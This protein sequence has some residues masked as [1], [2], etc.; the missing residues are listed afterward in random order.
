[1][2]YTNGKGFKNYRGEKTRVNETTQQGNNKTYTPP[3]KD[4]VRMGAQFLI[5]DIVQ[6]KRGALAGRLAK[7]TRIHTATNGNKIYTVEITKGSGRERQQ[8]T[9][10][11]LTLISRNIQRQS[12][13]TNE[14]KRGTKHD[15]KSQRN[16]KSKSKRP[17]NR[18]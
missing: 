2:R 6:I 9:G 15:F 16:S 7:V 3:V 14:N 4:H 8:L 17:I 12:N 10:E 5:D 1:M 11:E 18:R 13:I